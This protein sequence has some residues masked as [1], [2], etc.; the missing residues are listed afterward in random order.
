MAFG[1]EY[2]MSATDLDR[3]LAT[4]GSSVTR[5][6]TVSN[7]LSPG[8]KDAVRFTAAVGGPDMTLS[9]GTLDAEHEYT[10]HYGTISDPTAQTFTVKNEGTGASGVLAVNVGGGFSLSNDTCT[11]GTLAV[12]ATCSLQLTFTPVPDCAGLTAFG[13]IQVASAPDVYLLLH[14]FVTCAT[15]T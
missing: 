13:N 1:D 5:L 11:G 9:P 4:A 12:S 8:T 10:F 7:A 2:A 6:I 3:S 15:P 14:A